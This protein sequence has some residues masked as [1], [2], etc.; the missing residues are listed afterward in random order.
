MCT[1]VTLTC[2]LLSTLASSEFV[3]R[4]LVAPAPLVGE[5][6]LRC[7]ACKA[8]AAM[9]LISA[10]CVSRAN[11]PALRAHAQSRCADSSQSLSDSGPA[12]R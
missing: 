3:S 8:A 1:L 7:S 9:L 11:L 2:R 12:T 10:A 6:P 4:P 5:L